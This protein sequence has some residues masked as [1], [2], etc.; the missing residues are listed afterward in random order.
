MD[1][2]SCPDRYPIKFDNGFTL[3]TQV[4]EYTR[5]QMQ[6]NTNGR[7]DGFGVMF[8]LQCMLFEMR[9]TRSVFRLFVF[10]QKCRFCLE[11]L[12]LCVVEPRT[13]NRCNWM[14]IRK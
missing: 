14:L 11:N 6:Q 7:A 4:V 8:E 1:S 5:G 2:L 13:R 12:T 10:S 3:V 9:L